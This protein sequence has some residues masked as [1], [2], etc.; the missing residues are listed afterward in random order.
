M[1]D[2]T[3]VGTIVINDE[4]KGIHGKL[5]AEVIR[6]NQLTVRLSPAVEGAPCDYDRRTMMHAYE[7]H[8]HGRKC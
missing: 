3:S 8:G 1:D 4:L 2:A 6:K 7:L 5:R